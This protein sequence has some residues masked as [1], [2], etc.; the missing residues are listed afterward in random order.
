M[1]TVYGHVINW[2]YKFPKKVC[3]CKLISLNK[4]NLGRPL[5]LSLLKFCIWLIKFRLWQNLK[6]N[7]LSVMQQSSRIE[8]LLGSSCSWSAYQD[9]W[10]QRK[11]CWCLEEALSCYVLTWR[12]DDFEEAY[13]KLIR[14]VSYTD[15]VW[16]L[17]AAMISI[18]FGFC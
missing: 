5:F 8:A 4:A 11:D 3:I 12:L 18:L 17:N 6:T 7:I 13:F 10:P 9:Y 2:F 1:K 16:L 15:F 14:H